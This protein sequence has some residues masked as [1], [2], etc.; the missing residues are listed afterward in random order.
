MRRP[1][2]VQFLFLQHGLLIKQSFGECMIFLLNSFRFSFSNAHVHTRWTHFYSHRQIPV[3]LCWNWCDRAPLAAA[4]LYKLVEQDLVVFI[5]GNVFLIGHEIFR[6]LFLLSILFKFLSDL[7]CFGNCLIST[8]NF[9]HFL[10]MHHQ[11]AVK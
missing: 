3:F 6:L 4:D 10:L 1:V 7:L 9:R 11:L 8:G 2:L 5:D